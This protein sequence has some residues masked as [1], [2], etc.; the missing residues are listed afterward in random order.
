[1]AHN[2][3]LTEDRLKKELQ[4]QK[5]RAAARAHLEATGECVKSLPKQISVH[6][7]LNDAIVLLWLMVHAVLASRGGHS[8]ICGCFATERAIHGGQSAARTQ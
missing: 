2:R 4:A 5:A 8:H 6:I 3:L 1:M 7:Y